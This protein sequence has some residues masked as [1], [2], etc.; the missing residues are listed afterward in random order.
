[1]YDSLLCKGSSQNT[2]FR[3]FHRRRI[4]LGAGHG[5]SLKFNAYRLI[6]RADS[7]TLRVWQVNCISSSGRAVSLSP[8]LFLEHIRPKL[9][10]EQ[11]KRK[12]R[13]DPPRQAPHSRSLRVPRN[14][15]FD[16]A[17]WTFLRSRLSVCVQCVWSAGSRIL[18]S[19]LLSQF[20]H[21]RLQEV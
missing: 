7:A 16:R 3:E 17:F 13:R 1:M 5:N 15:S 9:D 20:H 19:R 21:R 8:G 11:C 10:K 14:P 4:I 12:A 18:V 6:P 2:E